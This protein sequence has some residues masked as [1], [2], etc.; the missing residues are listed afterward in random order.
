M[1]VIVDLPIKFACFPPLPSFFLAPLKYLP[2]FNV[3]LS[4]LNT[5][6]YNFFLLDLR[7]VIKFP[8]VSKTWNLR[9]SYLAHPP[10]S[11]RL[12]RSRTLRCVV[13]FVSFVINNL[14]RVFL[15]LVILFFLR[16]LGDAS[17]FIWK[18]WT[19]RLVKLFP[20][21]RFSFIGFITHSHHIL[22]STQTT[23]V[24][25]ALSR[26]SLLL[27]WFEIPH[28]FPILFNIRGGCFLFRPPPWHGLRCYSGWLSQRG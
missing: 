10:G 1:D 2:L 12:I 28:V 13:A 27:L 15:G 8:P 16:L 5:Q 17:T 3:Q 24:R 20:K 14:Y 6:H 19:N 18:W 23:G 26:L 11:P 25:D 7:H 22:Y 4:M 9:T 21:I